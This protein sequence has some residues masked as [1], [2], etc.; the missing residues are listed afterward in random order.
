MKFL[1]MMIVMAGFS[2]TL[3]ATNVNEIALP[4]YTG[5]N[6]QDYTGTW[7]G[8]ITDPSDLFAKG[9][10]WPVIISLYHKNGYIIGRVNKIR[11]SSHDGIE[12]RQIWASCKDGV[13]S[14][15]FWGNR[16]TC[17]SVSQEGMQVSKNVVVL[18][19]HWENAMANAD[20]LTFL[21]RKNNLYPYPVPQKLHEYSIENIK[22][23]H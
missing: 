9:G 3:Q 17:G 14:E 12:A 19:L 15:I 16:G 18:K 22:T 23:C 10:P 4:K 11:T 20:F 21:K 2:T 7:E 6:C 5:A 8:F 1:K 13:L